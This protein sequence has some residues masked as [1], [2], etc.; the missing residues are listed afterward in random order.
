MIR[1]R[2]TAE[3]AYIFFSKTSVFVLSPETHYRLLSG[4]VANKR[5]FCNEV[6]IRRQ[7]QEIK[8]LTS[9]VP[10]S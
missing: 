5:S 8:S 3:N 7:V 1:Q 10:R 6:I 2:Y 4:F 9:K